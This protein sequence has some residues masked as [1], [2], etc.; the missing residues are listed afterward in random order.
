MNPLLTG[1]DTAIVLK[2]AEA[3]VKAWTRDGRLP[4][5]RLGRSVRYRAEVISRVAELGLEA[6]RENKEPVRA[7]DALVG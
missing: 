4:C 1:K 3:T 5:V 6:A 7:G 2:V